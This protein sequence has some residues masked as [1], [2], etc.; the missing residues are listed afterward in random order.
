MTRG[1]NLSGIANNSHTARFQDA[2]IQ[3][4]DP[5]VWTR[6][7]HV[8]HTGFEYWGYRVYS[9]G[10]GHGG[11]LGAI[12]F[13]GAFTSEAPISPGPG[14]NGYGGADFHLG[15]PSAYGSG[16][17]CCVWGPRSNT[18][19]GYIQD[20]WR[21][22]NSLTLNLGLRYETF[23]PLVEKNDHQVNF[24]LITGQVLAPNCSKVNLGTAPTTCKNSS[25]GLYNGVY[26]GKAFQPRT[27][28]AWTPAAL[29]G[30]TVLRSAFPISA[31]L[32]CTGTNLR[33]RINP[34][35]TAAETVVQYKGVA[36]PGT[37]T[38]A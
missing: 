24:D 17:A 27:G 5:L 18:I 8:F 20:D 30:K 11:S 37:T 35:F 16:L 28:F 31:Y 14:G 34:P 12:L 7:R 21:A 33:L 10:S 3:F 29:G 9:F 6:N 25:R 32:E 2:V 38:D 4:S 13:S 22:T 26:G 36:L 19:A 1:G 23:T 15:L